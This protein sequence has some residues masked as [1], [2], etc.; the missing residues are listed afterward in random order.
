MKKKHVL[1]LLFLILAVNITAISYHF[2]QYDFSN[3]EDNNSLILKNIKGRL[4]P[5]VTN[6]YLQLMQGGRARN[7]NNAVVFPEIIEEK[8]EIEHYTFNLYISR[9]AEGVGFSLVNTDLF[10][11]EE[12]TNFYDIVE[13]ETFSWESP[14]FKGSFGLGIDVYNPQTSHWFDEWGNFYGREEREISL[15]WDSKEIYKM[16][17]PVEFR[18]SPMGS[19][20]NTFDL[21]IRYVT[22][23]AMISLAIQDTLIIEN[24]FIPEMTQYK[25]QAVFG[26]STGELTT[27]VILESFSYLCKGN[28][29]EF[30]LLESVLLLEG[31]VFHSQQQNMTI[32][33]YFPEITLTAD[34]VIMTLDLSGPEGGVSDWDV[35]ASIYLI[36][37]EGTRYEIL[38]YITPYRRPYLW[39]VDV[40]HFLPLFQGY[41]DIFAHISTWEPVTEDPSEQKGWQVTTLLDFYQG[42][43]E[44]RAFAVEQLWSGNFEYGHPEEPMKDLFE[45]FHIPIPSETK[46]AIFRIVTSGHGMHPNYEN[47][48]EFRPSDRWVYINGN[49]YHNLLWRTD[50]YLNPCRPQ[51]G[52]WKFDRAGW[53]PGDVVHAWEINL[54]EY[55][56]DGELRI[57]YHPDDYINHHR[58][59]TWE[60][61]HKIE[62]QVIFLK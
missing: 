41:K 16:M 45:D 5:E 2:K 15:H 47:A 21:T 50:N 28:A 11:E 22:A 18:A 61:F 17:S 24:Y 6:N 29:P 32:N 39:K 36:D 53:A 62:A 30:E 56:K 1:I 4:G 54:D 26:A 9:G 25:K 52:T 37:E 3:E 51:D 35:G 43:V 46:S 59:E 55:I 12:E 10:S 31:G 58:G 19:E 20:I 14:N 60:P 57:S 27:T 48:A 8:S 44:N 23:G 40:S 7:H 13:L 49:E 34:K 42:P 33:V 38:R